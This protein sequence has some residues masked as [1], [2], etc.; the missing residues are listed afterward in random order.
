V[1][2]LIIINSGI[3][4]SSQCYFD[5]ERA[6][7]CCGDVRKLKAIISKDE[8][9]ASNLHQIISAQLDEPE[10]ARGSSMHGGGNSSHG[11]PSAPYRADSEDIPEATVVS[12]G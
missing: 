2:A 4:S 12:Y 10:P 7:H 1:H 3:F 8:T 11:R 9:R 6:C 5:N